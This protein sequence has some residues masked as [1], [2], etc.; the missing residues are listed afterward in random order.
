M[1]LIVH[2]PQ[3]TDFEEDYQG[4]TALSRVLG[5]LYDIPV[6]EADVQQAASQSRSI[7]AALQDNPKLKAV[8]TELEN[9][10]ESRIAARRGKTDVPRLSPEVERFLKEQE[11]RLEGDK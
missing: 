3:Y 5:A 7:D 8:V 9:H 1:T 4:I 2:L 11:D 6:D 10:Y